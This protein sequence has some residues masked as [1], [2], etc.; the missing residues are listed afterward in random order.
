MSARGN[1]YQIVVSA[2]IDAEEASLNSA[3]CRSVRPGLESLLDPLRQGSPGRGP[4]NDSGCHWTW[5]IFRRRHHLPA[6]AAHHRI[7]GRMG[8]GRNSRGGSVGAI[9]LIKLPHKAR[10]R[11]LGACWR[12]RKAGRWP[13]GVGDAP[14]DRVVQRLILS[15][16][17][18]SRVVGVKAR[19]VADDLRSSSGRHSEMHACL[20]VH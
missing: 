6:F 11:R 2:G 20:Q 16:W 19:G 14:V 10:P 4:E 9:D 15:F 3:P 17:P 5:K 13:C 12:S 18:R 1:S 7:R 8:L